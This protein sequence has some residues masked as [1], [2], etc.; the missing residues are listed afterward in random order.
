MYPT[1]QDGLTIERIDNDGSYSPD[2]CRWATI[3]EQHLNR[4]DNHHLTYQGRTLTMKEWSVATGINYR[5]LR[6]RINESGW[7]VER[8][9]TTP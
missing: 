6:S 8:A 7:S 9:L 2:N 4:S 5:T 3:A 1:Y